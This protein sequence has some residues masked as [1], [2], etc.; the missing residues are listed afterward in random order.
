MSDVRKFWIFSIEFVL[1]I[2]N[3]GVYEEEEAYN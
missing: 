2:V 1:F 3:Y